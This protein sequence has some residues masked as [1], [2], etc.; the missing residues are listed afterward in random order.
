MIV[1]G[2]PPSEQLTVPDLFP[3][4]F[5]AKFLAVQTEGSSIGL[6]YVELNVL[7]FV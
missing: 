1:D 6:A 7:Y 5:E 4:D 2:G 3:V